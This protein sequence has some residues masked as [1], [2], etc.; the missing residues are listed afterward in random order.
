MALPRGDQILPSRIFGCVCNT[1]ISTV[2]TTLNLLMNAK[3]D[4]KYMK[5]V[6]ANHWYRSAIIC[7]AVVGSLKASLAAKRVHRR[8]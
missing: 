6:N 7:F 5:M 8:I 2:L 4:A 3:L 1:Q